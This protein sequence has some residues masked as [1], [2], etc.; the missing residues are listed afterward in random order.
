MLIR[1]FV[2]M[3]CSGCVLVCF[4]ICAI[5]CSRCYVRFPPW[6]VLRLCIGSVAVVMYCGCFALSLFSF[7]L[8]CGFTWWLFSLFVLIGFV[9][10]LLCV[11]VFVLVMLCMCLFIVV[12]TIF[13]FVGFGMYL[14][15]VSVL[16]YRICSCSYF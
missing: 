10:A 13:L 4:E 5:V 11:C 6:C 14:V 12:V 2:L 15:V 3:L 8:L 16:V 9:V 1:Y 7:V